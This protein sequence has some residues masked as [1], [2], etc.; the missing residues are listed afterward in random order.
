MGC[1]YEIYWIEFRWI[2][3]NFGLE[4]GD[5]MVFREDR[6]VV[7]RKKGFGGGANFRFLWFVR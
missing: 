2:N 5:I 4:H 6:E 7:F 3:K 1:I